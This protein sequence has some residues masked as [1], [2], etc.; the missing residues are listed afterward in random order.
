MS[1]DLYQQAQAAFQRADF[2]AALELCHSAL[3]NLD[4]QDPLNKQY[5]QIQADALLELKQAKAASEIYEEIKLFSQA[6]FAAVLAEDLP[7]ARALY[8]QA[9]ESPAAKWGNFLTDF[10]NEAQNSN[11][12]FDHDVMTPGYL[13]FRFY[14]EASYGYILN[15]QLK[16]YQ[17][18]FLDYRN[19]LI[20]V[21]P[22]LIKDMGSAHLARKEYKE[23]LEFLA[24][25]HSHHASDVG[26]H[27]K[28]AMAHMAL[29][30]KDQ[31]RESLL[32]VQ[33]MLPGSELIESLLNS[34]EN[35]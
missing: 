1:L 11:Y 28:S 13:V 25:A 31:A 26:I 32:N 33:K 24:E 35:T 10:L 17:R 30:H 34:I 22:E 18:R 27:F 21:Y 7:L 15:Y 19:Q 20:N 23:A 3:R 5:K 4:S 14:F 29:N 2:N 6:G 8:K 9:E 16:N 12:A